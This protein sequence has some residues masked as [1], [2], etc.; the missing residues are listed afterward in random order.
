MVLTSVD[1]SL[2]LGGRGRF[3][4]YTERVGF[5]FTPQALYPRA[6]GR[7]YS[8]APWDTNARRDPYP[9]GVASLRRS[10]IQPLR[11]RVRGG[12]RCPRV[13][14]RPWALGSNRFAVQTRNPASVRPPPVLVLLA[15]VTRAPPPL[16]HCVPV[17]VG[18]SRRAGRSG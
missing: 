5:V 6:Q 7:L 18:R 13:A 17:R 2:G 12:R 1:F 11:G 4:C 14:A 3:C 16:G 10:L 9:E 8:G 15:R